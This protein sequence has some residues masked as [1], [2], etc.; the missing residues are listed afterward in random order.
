MAFEPVTTLPFGWRCSSRP[1]IGRFP[2]GCA[3]T[4]DL[5]GAMHRRGD[6]MGIV[7]RRNARLYRQLGFGADRGVARLAG[8]H[9][10]VWY[11]LAHQP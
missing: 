6:V 8:A 1:T 4:G 10:S 11:P 2:R 9:V 7:E 3:R 5:L